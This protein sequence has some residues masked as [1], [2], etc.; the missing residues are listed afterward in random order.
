[1]SNETASAWQ[2]ESGSWGE[3]WLVFDRPGS[4]Q[5]S[6]DSAALDEL[7]AHVE[8]LPSEA[9][10]LIIR[11]GKPRGFCAGADLKQ[12]HTN[13]SR[14]Q[15]EAIGEKGMEV[16]ARLAGLSLPAV[17]LIHGVCL[18]GG[19]ELALA[20]T[21]RLAINDGSAKLGCPE[22]KVGLIPGW[23]GI[24]ALTRLVGL[25]P[26]LKMLLTGES[27]DANEA[28]R[29]G[30]LDGLVSPDSAAS[31]IWTFLN[32]TPHAARHR[33]QPEHWEKTLAD[34]RSNLQALDTE[35]RLAPSRL[36]DVLEI[37]LRDGPEAGRRAAVS[38]LAEMAMSPRARKAIAA[39]FQR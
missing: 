1:M 37:E 12:F 22:V 18:G 11:S 33:H 35:T 19:L 28:L 7:Q 32:S 26:A 8:S 29:I 24:A 20:C 36:L 2:R 15:V 27:V 10:A 3:I 30:L 14:E 31:E 34:A 25:E 13:P 4:S 6:L 17:A 9:R 39:F 5:N 21:Y 23:G 38:G 16:F